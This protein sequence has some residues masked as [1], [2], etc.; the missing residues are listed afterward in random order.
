M[1]AQIQ[2]HI[3]KVLK[4]FA[5]KNE[6]AR[7]FRERWDKMHSPLHSVAYMLEPQFRSARFDVGVMHL[8]SCH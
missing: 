2:Q 5:E 3:E 1:C 7:I 6:V 4:G 8:S